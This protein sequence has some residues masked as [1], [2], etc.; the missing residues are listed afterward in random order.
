MFIPDEGTNL[1]HRVL[2]SAQGRRT[3]QLASSSSSLCLLPVGD[4]KIDRLD[5]E[6]RRVD[7]D[8]RA[9][10]CEPREED[11]PCALAG[12]IYEE[13]GWIL[14]RIGRGCQRDET[15]THW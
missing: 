8:E 12:G 14:V 9:R 2:L 1:P 7:E 15:A 11:D 3:V 5:L 6:R 13:W 10:L 4:V